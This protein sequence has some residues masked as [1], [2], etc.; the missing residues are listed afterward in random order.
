MPKAAV[1]SSDGG[2]LIVVF[3]T[4]ECVPSWHSLMYST[5]VLASCA[6]HASSS[7]ALRAHPATYAALE[8]TPHPLREPIELLLWGIWGVSLDP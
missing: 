5:P 3:D 1:T 2:P 7:V 6:E 4:N 8:Y